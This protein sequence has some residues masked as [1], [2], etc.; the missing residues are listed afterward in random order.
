MM[1]S[2]HQKVFSL[3]KRTTTET[4]LFSSLDKERGSK[5][6]GEYVFFAKMVSGLRMCAR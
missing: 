1:V 6:G 3:N 4:A 2:S 5:K